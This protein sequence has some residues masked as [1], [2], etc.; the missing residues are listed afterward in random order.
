[1][2]SSTSKRRPQ[3]VLKER[4]D[5]L[6]DTAAAHVRL[7]DKVERVPVSALKPYAGNARRHSKKQIRQIAAS[8][9]E[10]GFNVPLLIEPDGTILSGHGR[11]EAALQLGM[12][13]LPVI[14]LSGL[15][16]ARKRALIL[17]ENRIAEN[18]SWDETKLALELKTIIELDADFE[19]TITGFETGEIDSRLQILSGPDE[20]DSINDLVMPDAAKAVTKPGDLWRC[21]IHHLL[22]GDARDP[23][24]YEQLMASERARVVFTDPPYNV[25]ISGH[26]MGKGAHQHREFAMARGEMT[27]A[28]FAEFIAG[29]IKPV[30]AFCANGAV[31]F[32]CMD[33][34]G[35]RALLTV[36]S[37]HYCELLN[38][39]VWNKSNGGMGSL[40]RS[41]HELIAVFKVGKGPHINNVALGRYGRN[42]TN[43]WD[44]AGLNAPV[45]GRDRALALHPTVKPVA[46]VADALRDCSHLGDIVLDPFCG[47]GTTLI[48]AEKTGRVARCMEID[49][50][51]VDAAVRRW[52]RA[53]GQKAVH[54]TTGRPFGMVEPEETAR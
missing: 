1:V 26:V 10:F 22:C 52:E 47:S 28:E 29:F 48:A 41:K 51:Y 43:V 35:L 54:A 2:G 14:R 18:A 6:L 30:I 49:P 45:A 12:T 5:T 15:S 40:Y 7:N 32:I 21:G 44:Y 53:T 11:L 46:M 4:T 16:E 23:S 27:E 31:N 9:R 20:Q 17:A 13:E 3:S 34:R 24:A 37:A 50:L 39:C 33:W 38:L 36:G 25:P 19:L 42:R 8:I